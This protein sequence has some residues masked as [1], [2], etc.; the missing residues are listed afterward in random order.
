ML[1]IALRLVFLFQSPSCIYAQNY[2]YIFS[3][4][5]GIH[6]LRSEDST[7]AVSLTAEY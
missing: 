1:K 5:W 3:H 4:V 2:I 7:K 6:M